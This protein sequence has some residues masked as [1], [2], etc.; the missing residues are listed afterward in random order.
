MYEKI[1]LHLPFTAFASDTNLNPVLSDL[2]WELSGCL[3]IPAR[4][5]SFEFNNQ[6]KT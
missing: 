6:M 3:E 4:V 2:A 1:C 5:P